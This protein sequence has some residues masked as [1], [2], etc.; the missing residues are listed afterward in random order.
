MVGWESGM[1][2]SI[3]DAHKPTSLSMEHPPCSFRARKIRRRVGSAMAFKMRFKSCSVGAMGYRN[4][5]C[6]DSCQCRPRAL[7][8]TAHERIVIKG[9]G[10]LSPGREGIRTAISSGTVRGKRLVHIPIGQSKGKL[11]DLGVL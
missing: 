6:I 5:L 3:S 2:C 4:R 1:R 8:Y 11:P 10:F 7:Q 9:D